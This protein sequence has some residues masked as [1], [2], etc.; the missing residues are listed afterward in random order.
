MTPKVQW[1]L[2]TPLWN[3]STPEDATRLHSRFHEPFI[4]RFASD[5]FMEEFFQ[6]VA[7][8]PHRIGEWEVEHETWRDPTTPPLAIEKMPRLAQRLF[9]LRASLADQA[10]GMV[11]SGTILPFEEASPPDKPLKLFQPGHQ[12]FYL[13][14]AGLVCRKPGLPEKHLDTGGVE[15]VSFVVRRLWPKVEGT[16]PGNLGHQHLRPVRLRGRQWR[17]IGV[18]KG[19]KP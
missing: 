1:T 5:N 10:V 17:Q 7:H 8:A 16:I 18:A 15:R 13:V 3:T 9:R 4:L 19:D 14:T 2:P 6:L 11:P 12:R